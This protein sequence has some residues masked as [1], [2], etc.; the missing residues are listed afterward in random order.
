MALRPAGA[1][2]RLAHG[3]AVRARHGGQLHRAQGPPGLF[4]ALEPVRRRVDGVRCCCSVPGPTDGARAAV[5][6]RQGLAL[7]PRAF[8]GSRPDVLELLPALDLF[9]LS[10]RFEGLPIAMLEAMA[11]GV[12]VVATRVGGIPEAVTDGREGKLVEPGDREGLAAA[13]R[14]LAA[15]SRRIGRRWAPRA[16]SRAAEFEIGS[17][18]ARHEHLY[19]AVLRGSRD[20]APK[21]SW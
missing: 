8:L 11:A 19:D 7:E 18:V 4:D 21:G 1:R 15:R 9:V 10:S 14:E 12:P 5:E 3:G 2:D 13:I 17:A 16:R 6:G 20:D